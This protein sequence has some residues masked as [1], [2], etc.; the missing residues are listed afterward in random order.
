LSRLTADRLCH[1]LVYCVAVS[2]LAGCGQPQIPAQVAHTE[3]T[4][5]WMLPEANKIKELL[6][7]S[8]G[9]TNE[10]YVYD[11]TTN[12]L[13]GR[14]G[15]FKYPYGQCVDAKGDVWITQF[16]SAE[17]IEYAHGGDSPIKTLNTAALN[18][19]FGCSIDPKTGN[20]AVANDGSSNPGQI[21]VFKG[22]SGTPKA[23]SS[24]NCPVLGS[25]GYDLKGN[26]YV[27]S[28]QEKTYA[29]CELARGAKSLK[30]M[31]M[32]QIIYSA[33]SVMWDG[34]Y[35]AVTDEAYQ[36][37][38]TT[39]IYQMVESSSGNLV[40]AGTTVLAD[41]C[42]GA[43]YISQPFIVGTVNTPRNRTQGTVV[44]GGNEGCHGR[45]DS[46]SYPA[47]GTPAPLFMAPKEPVGQSVSIA[48]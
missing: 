4:R 32:N 7:V 21:F 35:I 38:Q 30:A 18:Y 26:L 9:Y 37:N 17:V 36:G 14:L 42:G 28:G 25:P 13:V 23:Y 24:K 44:I 29:I 43:E 3:Q 41:D 5:S 6:Y 1:A 2:V 12:L 40:I 34:Q 22:A 27:E 45:F 33:G 8:D 47:G 31:E 11:F 10:V 16:S 19:S 46:W 39:A 20:L 48:Q 15:G